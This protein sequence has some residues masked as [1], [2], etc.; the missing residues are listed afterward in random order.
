MRAAESD[1]GHLPFGDAT[2]DAVFHYGGIAEFGDRA[3]AI[4]EMVRVAKSGARIVICDV[5]LPTD[6]KLSL[7]SRLLLRAQPAY[8]R[9]P[10]L[11]LIPAEVTDTALSWFGGGAWYLIECSKR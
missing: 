4:R 6:R 8:M 11:D 3:G 9:A 7:T 10:P 2:F 5:G 1:A